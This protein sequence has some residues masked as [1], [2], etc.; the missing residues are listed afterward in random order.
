MFESL[1]DSEETIPDQSDSVKCDVLLEDGVISIV[2]AQIRMLYIYR[3]CMLL[4]NK[5]LLDHD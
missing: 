5:C 4:I 1:K 3:A 2:L